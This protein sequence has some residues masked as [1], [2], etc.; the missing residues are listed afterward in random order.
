MRIE[1][2]AFLSDTQTSALVG[3]DGSVDWLCMPR[4][5]SPSCFAKLL[6]TEDN[7]FWKIAPAD[8]LK[9]TQRRYRD[10]TLI[11]DTEF[12]T[13]T[14][15]VR[16]TDFMPIRDE[17]PDFIRVVEGLD[18]EVPMKMKLALRFDYGRMIPWVR[19]KE[20]CLVAIAGPNAILLQ[21]DVKTHGEDHST[22][23]EFTVV[24]GEKI[25]FVLTW[26]PSHSS[27]PKPASSDD[28]LKRTACFWRD[29]S[30]R[31]EP[32]HQW[33]EAVKK[34]L[35]VLKGL[36]YAP[37]GGIVAAATTSLPEQLGG[38][39]NWDYRFCWLRDATFTLTA[40]LDAGYTEE[41]VAWRDWLLRAAAG[42]PDQL[43]VLYGVAGEK[44]LT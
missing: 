17:S 16:L 23:A 34:S 37:T 4:F 29:W 25:A 15:R 13:G 38:Y 35:L 36:T 18:G 3:R 24:A 8:P 26:F 1:D 40:F 6:G 12:T 11:L 27:L 33:S 5:D 10:G 2:Y 31:C 44:D 9:D 30:R 43:Q 19:Q 22:A 21:S 41:A 39:H 7:G 20:G 14:G 32:A 42:S 28:A